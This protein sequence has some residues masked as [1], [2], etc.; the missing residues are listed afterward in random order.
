MRLAIL[1]DVHGN[2]PALEAVLAE[3]DSIGVDGILVAGDMVDGPQPL[4]VLHTLR[5]RQACM[6]R[7]NREKYMLAYYHGQ[8]PP[9]WQTSEQWASLRWIYRRLDREA[10]EHMAA[11]PEQR[12]IAFD[13][14]APIRMVHGA[15]QGVSTL[16]L[17]GRDPDSMAPFER[18]RLVALS[19]RQ[20]DLEDALAAVDEPVL[21]CGH[22]HTPWQR[23]REVAGQRRLALNPGSVGGPLNGD[24]RAQYALLTWQDGA[25][26]AEH[27]LVAYDLDRLQAAYQET[28]FVEQ[29]G[30]FAYGTMVATVTGTNVLGVFVRYLADLAARAGFTDYDTIPDAVWQQATASFDWLAEAAAGWHPGSPDLER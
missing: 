26:Q 12:T 6:I 16:L 18:A 15:P 14:A 24:P 23:V 4:G 27:R 1:A 13:G 17:P 2:L 7:G 10:L 5:A 9:T 28:R 29:G 30:A 19:Y 20:A 25:W 22:S 8:T 3:V 21:V 11:L